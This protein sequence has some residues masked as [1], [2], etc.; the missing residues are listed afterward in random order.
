MCDTH[1]TERSMV[2]T[3]GTVPLP[4][5]T[6][7]FEYG[8]TSSPEFGLRYGSTYRDPF[9]LRWVTEEW[10]TPLDEWEQGDQALCAHHAEGMPLYAA[11]RYEGNVNPLA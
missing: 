7:C 1:H 6:E 2:P 5:S 4:A 3:L 8:C 10:V 11:G 9:T